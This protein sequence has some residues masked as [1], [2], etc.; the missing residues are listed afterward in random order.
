MKFYS[1]TQHILLFYFTFLHTHKPAHRLITHYYYYYHIYAPT[2]PIQFSDIPIQVSVYVY[3][4]I[5]LR[6]LFLLPNF[7]GN[8]VVVVM[9]VRCNRTSVQFGA[10]HF[11]HY[12]IFH[13]TLNR[14]KEREKRTKCIC[15]KKQSK[16]LFLHKL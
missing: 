1:Y 12:S 15:N 9:F 10:T 2:K 14:Q 16:I 6:M 11:R 5:I 8:V 7:V 3:G 13:I 4:S